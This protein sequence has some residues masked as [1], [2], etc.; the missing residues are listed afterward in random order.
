MAIRLGICHAVS[1]TC[2]NIECVSKPARL[3]VKVRVGAVKNLRVHNVSFGVVDSESLWAPYGI[4]GVKCRGPF[5]E[6]NENTEVT[7]VLLVV[8]VL[9]LMLFQ[10]TRKHVAT[11]GDD[12]LPVRKDR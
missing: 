10:R 3:V 6:S 4:C 11:D 7:E 2:C 1:M 9:L 8:S 5:F 12:A